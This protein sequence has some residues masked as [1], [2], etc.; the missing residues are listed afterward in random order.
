M[1]ER[2]VEL[3]MGELILGPMLRHVSDSTATIFVETDT[4]A[5]V[6]INGTVTSTFEVAGHHY[7]LVIIEGLQPDSVIP[8]SVLVDGECR[9]PQPDSSMPPS[10]F[11]RAKSLSQYHSPR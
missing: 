7:A 5:S 4:D 2:R 1:G 6:D 8:Y 10:R 11:R 3:N 9:W